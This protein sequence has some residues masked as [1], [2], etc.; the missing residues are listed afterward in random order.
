MTKEVNNYCKNDLGTQVP[1][2]VEVTIV[3]MEF[4]TGMETNVEINRLRGMKSGIFGE[5][6]LTDTGKPEWEDSPDYCND[7]ALC[8]ELLDEQGIQFFVLPTVKTP[9]VKKYVPG[10]VVIFDLGGTLYST[11]P[12]PTEEAALACALWFALSQ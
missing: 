7:A 8:A 12:Q 6:A 3:G 5:R 4:T 2:E 11:E 10:M 9:G 1:K